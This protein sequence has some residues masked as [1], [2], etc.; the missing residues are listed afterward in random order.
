[1]LEGE[2]VGKGDPLGNISGT[3]GRN[4]G[5]N[6]PP[7]LLPDPVCLLTTS[8]ATST[9]SQATHAGRFQRVLNVNLIAGRQHRMGIAR[10]PNRQGSPS[11]VVSRPPT[12]VNAFYSVAEDVGPD[13]PQVYWEVPLPMGIILAS[14]KS[15]IDDYRSRSGGGGEDRP[16][17]AKSPKATNPMA[18]EIALVRGWPGAL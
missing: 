7:A 11:I 10:F 17:P 8:A 5:A 2:G 9:R 18:K 13:P 16:I 14:K 1:M 15:C 4:L 3:Q 6:S 12:H